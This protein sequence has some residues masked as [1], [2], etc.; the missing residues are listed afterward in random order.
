M[1]MTI[2]KYIIKT[3]AKIIIFAIISIIA[4]TL[5]G[6]PVIKNDIYLGQME[7]SDALFI[8]MDIYN[9]LTPIIS[10][11]YGCVTAIFAGTII[12]DTYKFIKNKRKVKENEEH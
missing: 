2:K 9:K 12:Y 11:I 6:S 7:N 5:L 1:P 8:L 4:L 10:V 3:T